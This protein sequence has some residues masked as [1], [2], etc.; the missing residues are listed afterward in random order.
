MAGITRFFSA[1]TA[2][3]LLVLPILAAQFAGCNHYVS[4]QA[5]HQLRQSAKLVQ[6]NANAQ[7]TRKLLT[8]LEEQ[9]PNAAA[10]EALYLLG[11]CHL[12]SGQ[13]DQARRSFRQAL[14]VAEV[15]TLQH[16]LSLSLANLAFE[17][18]DYAAAA[19]LYGSYLD[20]LPR[21][22]PFQWAHY[23]YGLTL[24]TVGKWKQAD[25]Q[26]SRILHLFQQSDAYD[27]A[28]KHFGHTHYTIELGRFPSPELAQE[29]RRQFPDLADQIVPA[30]GHE[31]DN[32]FYVNNYGKFEKL[33]QAKQA[34]ASIK[35]I[36]GQARIVP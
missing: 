18:G 17:Q 6:K 11:I 5:K 35:Q 33:D 1:A 21:R 34:L 23:R 20:S 24:Q 31:P 4:E 9:P 13:T 30:A 36:A 8:L 3:L 12:R 7:A 32:W 19:R 14:D 16:Y 2:P 22:S 25:V 27:S 26:F 10:S 28:W 29:Q 15:T